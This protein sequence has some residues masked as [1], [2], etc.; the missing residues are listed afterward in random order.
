MVVSSMEIHIRIA[1]KRRRVPPRSLKG[2]DAASILSHARMIQLR[3]SPCAS[4][5]RRC[6]RISVLS[7]RTRVSSSLRSLEDKASG[8][9]PQRPSNWRCRSRF[10]SSCE[11]VL[12][13]RVGFE[14]EGA[15]LMRVTGSK[16]RPDD[17][18]MAYKH[19]PMVIRRPRAKVRA[20]SPSTREDCQFL[21]H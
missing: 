14:M 11:A 13:L 9:P 6:R 2:L 1:I 16:A 5:I 18:Y 4:S 12:A 19:I 7:S 10:S 21:Q 17:V 15:V 8:F 20:L 3:R